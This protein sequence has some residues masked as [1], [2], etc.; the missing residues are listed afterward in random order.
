MRAELDRV[1]T[2]FGGASPP[3]R[4]ASSDDRDPGTSE[5]E[6]T[7]VRAI[8]A[9]RARRDQHFRPNMFG[10]PD[11]DMFL[12]LFVAQL[13][14][15]QIS[16]N[17][18]CIAARVPATTALRHITILERHGDIQ[19][20]SDP[21]DRRRSFLRLSDQTFDGMRNWLQSLDPHLL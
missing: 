11:W 7:K 20:E 1:I 8:I 5:T 2:A 15:A 17:S 10:E 14:G 18:L 16:V 21:F 19:R 12:D 3:A 4:I 6:V 9:A 13:T